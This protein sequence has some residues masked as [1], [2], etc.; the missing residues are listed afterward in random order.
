MWDGAPI[1]RSRVINACLASGAAKRL[2]LERLPGYAPELNPV[3]AVW[4]YLNHVALR[5]VGCETLDELQYA[6]RLA[7]ANLVTNLTSCAVF[8]N[9]AV[10][11]FRCLSSEQ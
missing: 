3:E 11:H 4:H 8:P 7:G 9:I 1:H 6:V 2:Q 5:N 10:M